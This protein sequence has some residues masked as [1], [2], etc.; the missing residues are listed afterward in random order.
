MESGSET[1]AWTAGSVR[2]GRF[3]SVTYFSNT[4]SPSAIAA[5][6]EAAMAAVGSRRRA[7]SQQPP[8]NAKSGHLTHQA[9]AT[10]K[11]A[12]RGPQ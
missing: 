7:A 10:T 12:V 4:V 8:V 6:P 11:T 1:S 2:G 5:A 9:D 3:R